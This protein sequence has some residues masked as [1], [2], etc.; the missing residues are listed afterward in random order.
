MC[1]VLLST[2]TQAQ[3]KD[4]KLTLTI[5]NATLESFV[6]QLENATGFSFVYGEE[7]KVYRRITVEA[8]ELTIAEIL[9]RAFAHEPVAFEISGKHILLRKRPMPERVKRRRFSISGFLTDKASGETL[10]GAN[11]LAPNL[12][13]GTTTNPYGFYTL[14]LPEGEVELHYS[15]LGYTPGYRSFTLERDTLLNI[16]LESDNCLDEVV[17]LSDKR[18]AG[19]RSTAMGAHEIPLTQIQHTPAVMGEAD[20]LKTIQLMPG[21]QAG[22]EGFSGL[23]VRGGGSDQNLILMDGIPVY[24]ADHLLGIFS[25][26]T[27]EAVKNV[28]LY[29]S[30]FPARYGGRLSSIVDVRTNDGDLKSYH[31]SL[32]VGTL[33]SKLHLEGPIWKDHTSFSISGRG[34]HTSLLLPI[35]NSKDDQYR[36]YFY[37]LN[38]KLSHKFNE[39]SRMFLNVYNGQDQF[40][41]MYKENFRNQYNNDDASYST[42]SQNTTSMLWGNTIVAGRWN[43]VFSNQ[44]FGNF[45]AAY[46]SYRMRINNDNKELDIHNAYTNRQDF[47]Y[48]YRSGIRDWSFRSDFDYTPTPAHD[49]KFGVEY[50]YHIFRPES[51]HTRMREDNNG[52]TLQDTLYTS[53]AN[54][55]L[56]GHEISLYAEDDLELSSHLSMNLGVHLSLFHT[57]GKSYF[58]AQPRI[59][60]RYAFDNGLAFKAGFSQMEQYVHLL[61]STPLSMPTDLWV[62]ITR[63]IRPMRA[64]QYSAGIYYTGLA[65]WEFSL[66]AYYKQLNNVLEYKD[67]VTLFG[68]SINWED[69]VEIGKGRSK[70]MEFMVQKTQG[71]TTGWLSY[72]LA[73]SDRQFEN[74]TINNGKPFPYKYDRRHGINLCLNHKFNERIDIGASWIFNTGGTATIAERR[75]VVVKPDGSQ[76]EENY[77]SGRNNYR[78][79]SSHR[80][81]LGINFNRQTKHGMRTWNISI[82]NAYNAMNPSLLYTTRETNNSYWTNSDD[83]DSYFFEQ[84]K[85]KLKKVTLLPILPSVTYTY[86]F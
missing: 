5:R 70:G 20:V 86:R 43:Y 19:I 49:I 16:A 80:L 40:R 81:N 76:S 28:T 85:T 54:N 22:M 51:S 73:K 63:R 26:F 53:P 79:P 3:N 29:K 67:G 61:S 7:I 15:Y 62:P 59:S 77:I 42:Y 21:V 14:T 27:P 69:K 17:V 30:S 9:E 83:G 4:V 47:N 23:Y 66:E 25:I 6:K 13:T 39:R 75:T 10:I 57:Q 50:L 34:T 58:S 8:K 60:T 38:A 32:S 41:W 78:L 68:T 1:V 35:F 52:Q 71:R 37:D 64:N 24:N 2:A 46:N 36:Y 12:D 11:I 33:T 72:T 56:H 18:D 65:G 45:T 55:W 44:L 31:G 74:G 84:G 48:E 82:Y